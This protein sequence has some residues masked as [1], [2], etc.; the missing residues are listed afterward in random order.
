MEK[1]VVFGRKKVIALETIKKYSFL[2]AFLLAF[3]APLWLNAVTLDVTDYNV[4]GDGITDDSANFQAALDAAASQNATLLI[5][6]DFTIRVTK[7]LFIYGECN[8]VGA[9]VSSVILCDADLDNDFGRAYWIC[10]GITNHI[11]EIG[12]STDSFI[13]TIENLC[14]K[15][16][17]NAKFNRGVFFFSTSDA[18]I[19]NVL[20]DFMDAL[21]GEDDA[22][23]GATESGN[24]ANWALG[25]TR[26]NITQTNNI[27]LANHSVYGSEGLGAGSAENV[28]ISNNY[29]Y[30]VGDDPIG[31]H[32]I[33]N[34]TIENN[35]CYSID[36]RILANNSTNVKINNNY[37]ERIAEFGTTWIS[38]G[39]MI[40]VGFVGNNSKPAP[41]NYE[42]KNNVIKIPQQ[43]S[44]YTYGIRIIRGRDVTIVSN[45]LFM[46]SPSGG[47]GINIEAYSNPDWEDPDGIDTDGIARPRDI[48]IN[49]NLCTGAYPGNIYQ[50]GLASYF[51]SDSYYNVYDNIAGSYLWYAY[52]V[53]FTNSNNIVDG[54]YTGYNV[55]L[56]AV[57]DPI[58]LFSDFMDNVTPGTTSLGSVEYTTDKCGKMAGYDVVLDQA[59]TS[60]TIYLELYKNDVLVVSTQVKSSDRYIL[61]MYNDDL[62]YEPGDVFTLKA[63]GSVA[64]E[65]TGGIDMDVELK[66]LETSLGANYGFDSDSSTIC[67][68][69]S[70]NLND[71]SITGASRVAGVNGNALNF[72]GSNY[73]TVDDHDSLDISD[74][75]TISCWIN[76]SDY[77]TNFAGFPIEKRTN[78]ADA[79]FACYYYG[80][81]VHQGKLGFLANAGGTWQ[82]ISP[83]IILP[84]K[85]WVHVALV[86][87]AEGGGQMY[88]NGE[89]HGNLTGSGK[90]AINA[91]NLE[92]GRDFKGL[93]DEVRIYDRALLALE[94][95]SIYFLEKRD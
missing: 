74:N 2:Y 18:T 8:V 78:T 75:L 4:I 69:N 40:Y 58:D 50:C 80:T 52:S 71:G 70:G 30:G 49:N 20:F 31:C 48:T 36:G 53:D 85:E 12:A 38:G 68:D 14:I 27:V 17:S 82:L 72:D 9:G 91:A 59:V 13:G 28:T 32:G 34:L 87:T 46:D 83:Y 57:S 84:Q 79:N 60:G 73:V 51:P 56:S 45:V 47:G 3:F 11:S 1:N 22:L 43:I 24:N 19:N 55:S 64:M 93:I 67:I 37:C 65:P 33:T 89:A 63:R 81:G 61:N 5:P 95:K 6:E 90:L 41:Q 92:I 10:V 29:I 42:I 76:I 94:V 16:S 26:E 66:A 7:N 25:C 39:A 54:D 44:S 86:Y 15:A 62:V 21:P 88:I 77:P 35:F 23:F